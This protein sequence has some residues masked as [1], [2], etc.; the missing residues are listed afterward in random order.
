MERPRGISIER[1]PAVADGPRQPC[2]D[3]TD[4][5]EDAET[6]SEAFFVT[7][8]LYVYPLPNDRALLVNTLSGAVDAVEKRLSD[9]LQSKAR[10]S[11]SAFTPD[12]RS[13]LLDRGY[14]LTHDRQQEQIAG[15]F[16][17]FKQRLRSFHFIV[18]PTQTCNLRCHYCYE[19]LEARQSRT[20][21]SPDHVSGM[22]SAMDRLIEERQA[23]DVHVEFFGGEPFLRSNRAVVEQIMQEIAG[24]QWTM[25]GIT[26]GT[27]I[28][29]YLPIFQR[30]LPQ[31]SQLQ[32]TLDGP[33]H[34][35]DA[36]RVNARGRGSYREICDNVTAL[37]KLPVPVVLRVNTG[38]DTV[39]QLPL[40]FTE[41]ESMGWTGY[42]HF[43]CQLAP[44]NDH[45]CT[46]CVANYQPEFKL[47]RQ[48]HAVFDDWE[49]T[50]E[51]YRVTLG[52]DME[53]RTSLLRA[54]LYDKQSSL[55]RSRDLSGCSA[56]NQHYAVFGAD[57]LIYA[58]PETVGL[59]EAAVGRYF[60]NLEIDRGKWS[61]WDVNISNT[62]KCVDCNI[63]PVCGGACPWHG[64]NASSYEA[65]EPHCN[66][67]HQTI[68]TYLE[69]NQAR[70]L[71]LL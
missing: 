1:T 18:C 71:E 21:M 63:A 52:Y 34:M 20:S 45:G 22:L 38:V 5:N 11:S 43:F 28:E 41:F 46:G 12:E 13:F 6:H 33:Q 60:P 24:R 26:N 32:I 37:L 54:A 35:H 2:I 25:S 31:L 9:L 36:I 44:I 70:L 10:R 4:T 29:E 50:R 8:Y 67:A 59:T 53:R 56:S 58:C 27:Q 65:Y 3:S 61:R 68:A 7:Q 39:D 15:W 30:F 55:V 23:K 14:L 57:G 42:P 17:G 51:R 66:Y 69:V 64:I 47:L 49:A 19:P 62:P 16:A 40:L 48:L